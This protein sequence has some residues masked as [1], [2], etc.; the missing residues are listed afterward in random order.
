[1]GSSAPLRRLPLLYLVQHDVPQ[2]IPCQN[3]I[4]KHSNAGS[5]MLFSSNAALEAADVRLNG[6]ASMVH[7]ELVDGEKQHFL[8]VHIHTDSAS[9]P[10][11]AHH[12]GTLSHHF[13]SRGSHMQACLQEPHNEDRLGT[14]MTRRWNL[15]LGFHELIT[16]HDR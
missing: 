1:M 11:R 16:A 12:G 7:D 10:V 2:R 14:S 13:V 15:S 9:M 5:I 3:K 4:V 6:E 8:V